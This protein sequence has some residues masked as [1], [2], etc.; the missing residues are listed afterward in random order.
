MSRHVVDRKRPSRRGPCCISRWVPMLRSPVSGSLEITH[1]P[2]SGRAGRIPPPYVTEVGEEIDGGQLLGLRF[3]QTGLEADGHAGA[4]E[5]PQGALQFDEVH[6]GGTSWAFRAM[7]S[8][9]WVSSRMSG[10]TW[11]SVRGPGCRTIGPSP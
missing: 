11:R 8:R 10:S 2:A 5:L 6:G 1:G 7:T 4:A 9:S 3:E